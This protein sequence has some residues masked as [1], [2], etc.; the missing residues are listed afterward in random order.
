[1]KKSEKQQIKAQINRIR[2][3]TNLEDIFFCKEATK[4]EEI[5]SLI[6]PYLTW[7]L[8]VARQLEELLNEDSKA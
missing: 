4:N 6:K 2:H 1:M 8:V 7:F 3:L 5:K